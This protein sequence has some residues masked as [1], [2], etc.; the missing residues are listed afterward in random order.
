MGAITLK[1]GKQTKNQ[2][3]QSRA[4]RPDENSICVVECVPG[5]CR[6]NFDMLLARTHDQLWAVGQEA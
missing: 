3:W 5:S 4:T 2:F 6:A 1:G